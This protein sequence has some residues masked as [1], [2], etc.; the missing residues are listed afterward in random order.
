MN[1]LSKYC[2]MELYKLQQYLEQDSLANMQSG[3]LFVKPETEKFIFK[4]DKQLI[5]KS[6][7]VFLKQ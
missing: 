5:Y 1:L 2:Q 3:N 6:S 7:P 4:F